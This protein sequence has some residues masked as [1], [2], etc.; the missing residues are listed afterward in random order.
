MILLSVDIISQLFILLDVKLWE[1][2]NYFINICSVDT[3]RRFVLLPKGYL[4][5]RL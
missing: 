3:G 1:V 5:V 4:W 2:P